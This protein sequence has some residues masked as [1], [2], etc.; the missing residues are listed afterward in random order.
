MYAVRAHTYGSPD[1]LVYEEVP[2]LTAGPGQILV[3]VESAAVNYADVMRRS[4]APYPFPTALPFIPGSEVA[5]LV[6][7]LGPGVAGPPVG[8][9]VFA[10]V[11]SDGSSGYAQY[12]LAAAQQVIPLP[13]TLSADE[14]CGLVVAGG[15]AL[16]ALRE[17]ARLQRGE[18]VLVQG[19]AG[20][21]G[22]YAIQ[23]ARLLGAGS[24]IGAA[25]SAAKRERAIALGADQAID[26]THPDWPNHV[27]EITGG[28]G[29]D[30]VLE[31]GG[32]DSLAQSLN[33]L[34][35]FGRVV[36][37]GAASRLPARLDEETILRFFYTPA[38]NQSLHVF[39]L[40]LWFGLKPEPAVAALGDLIGLAASGQIKPQIGHVFPLAQAAEAHRLLEERQTTGKIVLKPWM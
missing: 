6:A 27:R 40:G 32:G 4:N 5:G 2:D 17:I 13:P 34:A 3:K 7:A 12:A 25:S 26:Y 29:V 36:V 10:L 21:V 37:L 16:F 30:V 22:S 15:T 9:P 35:P 39:N 31:M 33:C 19:A 1:V 11:G 20:G 28:Q 8:T 24:I 18:A 38:L 23:I 14:A